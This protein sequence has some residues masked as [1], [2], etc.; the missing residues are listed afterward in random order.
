MGYI[1]L[2]E[3]TEL[4]DRQAREAKKTKQKRGPK[5]QARKRSRKGQGKGRKGG[6]KGST[7]KNSGR[8]SKGKGRKGGK[9]KSR[10][11]NNGTKGK[12]R[13]GRK[14]D[15]MFKSRGS[16]QATSRSCLDDLLEKMKKF[17]KIQTEL[18]LVNSILK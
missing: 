5:N 11:K 17:N 4:P 1:A 12:G 2:S 8:K 14:R 7:V 3:A 10:S 9:V 13:N 6:R 18:K 15:R 16:L